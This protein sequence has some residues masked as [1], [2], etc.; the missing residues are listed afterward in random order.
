MEL[1]DLVREMRG[2]P[3]GTLARNGAAFLLE[4]GSLRHETGKF[5]LE[6]TRVVTAES[7][8]VESERV[9]SELAK[10]RVYPVDRRDRRSTAKGIM[11]GRDAGLDVRIDVAT[12]SAR[13]ARLEQ[14]ERGRWALTDEHSRNGTWIDGTRMRPGDT[15]LLRPGQLVRFGPEVR[16]TFLDG[17]MM[18]SMLHQLDSLF[19]PKLV[20]ERKSSLGVSL[21]DYLLEDSSVNEA[22]ETARAPERPGAAPTGRFSIAAFKAKEPL[23]SI[24]CKPFPAISLVTGMPVT[25]G[26]VPGNDLILPHPHVSRHHARFERKGDRIAVIDLESANGTWVSNESVPRADLSV[27][28]RVVIGPFEI[29]LLPGAAEP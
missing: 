20:A 29:Q 27:G 1:R 21:P 10:R 26:R 19:P 4:D 22:P 15:S 17:D 9:G 24:V 11:V 18:E 6:A 12:V 2:L 16:L 14:V 28:A 3:P 13:H 8:A 7:I 5:K 25:V 23:L